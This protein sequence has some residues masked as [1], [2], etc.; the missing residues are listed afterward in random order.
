V[1]AGD[2]AAT[3]PV[4]LRLKMPAGYTIPAHWH[5]TDEHVTVLSGTLSA[6]VHVDRVRRIVT[7]LRATILLIFTDRRRPPP[8]RQA[9]TDLRARV[10]PTLPKPSG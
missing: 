6:A 8:R 9:Q 4:A 10:S 2:P 1:M 7:T 5:P 3:G